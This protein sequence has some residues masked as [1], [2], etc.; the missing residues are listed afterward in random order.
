MADT[1]DITDTRHEI[2]ACPKCQVTMGMGLVTRKGMLAMECVGSC[3]HR[4]TGI[5]VPVPAEWETWSISSQD[6]DRLAFE[7]WNAEAR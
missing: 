6:R 1:F 5:A 4:S 7:A 3:G 2:K